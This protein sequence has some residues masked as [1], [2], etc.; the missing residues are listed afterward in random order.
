MLTKFSILHEIMIRKMMDVKWIRF[1]EEIASIIEVASLRYRSRYYA[2]LRLEL[3]SEVK[4]QLAKY[5]RLF[6]AIF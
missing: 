4:S 5:I 3:C 1:T 6:N 2:V